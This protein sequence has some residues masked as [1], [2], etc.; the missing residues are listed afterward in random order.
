MTRVARLGTSE[1]HPEAGHH[2]VEHEQS[3]VPLRDLPESLQEALHGLDQTGVADH[4]L[5]EH[6]CQPVALPLERV[7]DRVQIVERYH[8]GVPGGPP[9][10]A[11]RI[12]E[13]ERR[14]TTASGH[15]ESVGVA[16]VAAREL[17]QLFATRDRP[18][19]SQSAH[20]SLGPAVDQPHHLDRGH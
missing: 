6:R 4:R 18:R 19:E 1:R 16:V 2:F 8:D 3:A 9:G 15:E 20:R 17:E 5:D 7:A 11:G 14:N 13:A 10:H 12:W